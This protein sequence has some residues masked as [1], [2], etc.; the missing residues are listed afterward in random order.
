VPN[1][2][3]SFLPWVRQ[4]AASAITTTDTLGPGQSAVADVSAI[5]TLNN[6]PVPAVAVRLRGPADVAGIDAN[7]IVRTDPRPATSSFEPNCFPSI[8]FDRPDFPWLFTPARAN[9]NGKLRPWLCLIVVQK[10]SGVTV[11]SAADTPL[12]SLRID[13]PA[14]PARELPH[15]A[16]CWAW[17]HTQVVADVPGQ[18]QISAAL[19]GPPELSLSRLVCPRILAANTDYVACVV[20]TFELGRKTGLGIDIQDADLTSPNALAPAWSFTPSPPAQVELPVYYH[21]EFRTGQAGD[22]ESL[23]RRLTPGVPLGF[24]KRSID[25]SRPGFPASGAT[26]QDMEGALL[27]IPP[28]SSTSPSSVASPGLPQ[29]FQT[30]LANIINEPSRAQAANPNAD[31]LLA[32]P[33]YGRWHAG[34]GTVSPTATTW[35]DQLNL[36]PRWRVAAAL[37]THVVQEHQEALVASA[38][39][40]AA[41]LDCANQRLRQFQVSMAVG[42]SLHARHLSRLPEE[43]MLRVAAPAFGRLRQPAGPSLLALQLSS[44]LPVAATRSAMR[45]I[46]RQRGP[47]TRRLA[48]HG[49]SR[50]AVNSWVARLNLMGTMPSV[51]PV[52]PPQP[53]YCALPDLPRQHLGAD[54]PPGDSYFG[55]FRVSPERA[56]VSPEGP[57]V[58]VQGKTEVPGLFRAAAIAHLARVFA[59]RARPVSPQLTPF[60]NITTFVVQQTH[61]RVA[62]PTLV[63]AILATGDKVLSATAPGVSPVGVET[64]MVTP[65][66]PQ[67]MY[68]PLRDLSQDYLLPGLEAVVPDTVLGL[69]T[70]RRFVE[71]YMVGLNHEMGREL[72]WRGYPTDQRG[73]YFDHF[74]GLGVP[75]AAPAD[76]ADLNTWNTRSLGDPVSGSTPEEFVMLLRSAL[77][78]R[79]PNA[80]I[81]LTPALSRGT[82]PAPVTLVPDELPAHEIPPIFSGSTPP[83]VSFFGFPISTQAATGADGKLGYYVII[84][85]H[86]TEPRFGVDV[87]LPLG[88]ASH[89]AVGSQ[90]PPGLPL[91]GRTWGKNS[92]EMAGITRRL[93]VRIAIH[94]ARLVTSTG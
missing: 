94:A 42:E 17:A 39:E 66:F 8:E 48:V 83:D 49:F 80:V 65:S 91:N 74:W 89:L 77:L 85:E 58:L 76:I 51:V 30:N 21:W 22:F 52:L 63:N 92:A 31:P 68:E 11:V 36:D 81:Y 60:P 38:W 56:P 93:P 79:Y 3:L 53:D 71:S 40:Q 34:R 35:L 62:L 18:T 2:S 64:L 46:G 90:P 45:R 72:L 86:P 10:Q 4:G 57:A 37:G 47:L 23:A 32:P 54:H 59:P 1:A 24:G 15:L 25:V 7:Q 50:V 14:S 29:Q 67:P 6:A 9:S 5:V 70:N 12:P 75:N 28:A 27:P 33:I 43:T 61:P 20:P 78:Q 16:E 55:V 41:E 87:N 73:T 88:T 82:P 26:T 19:N 13:A 44:Q 69:R 84:Q